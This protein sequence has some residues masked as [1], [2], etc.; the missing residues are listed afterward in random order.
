M[1]TD[2]AQLLERL[3]AGDA[4]AFR[5]VFDLYADRLYHVA[6]RI[7]ES[8]AEAEAIVQDTFTTLIEKLE[9]FEGRSKLGTWLYR[10]AYNR[11]LD[12]AARLKREERFRS[13]TTVEADS[14]R[15]LPA[16]I[17]LVDWTRAPEAVQA[18]QE[19]QAQIDTALQSL[20]EALRVV[21][22]LREMEGFST[23]ETA[24]LLGISESAVKV[25][26]HRARLHLRE[27]LSA[28]FRDVLD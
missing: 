19:A 17:V 6:Y 10:V 7:V 25:R 20:S 8:E 27:E 15:D 18:S 14:D 16:P 4:A 21:F 13:V 24:A 3:R 1:T 5:A 28:Y 12:C 23:T 9:T 26:L 11:A 22:T 2:D